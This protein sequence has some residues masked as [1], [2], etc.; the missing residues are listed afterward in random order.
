MRALARTVQKES[1]Y[2]RAPY[3]FVADDRF[4]KNRCTHSGP[5][6]RVTLRGRVRAH[7][8]S[9]ASGNQS[10]PSSCSPRAAIDTLGTATGVT[11]SWVGPAHSAAGD[12]TRYSRHTSGRSGWIEQLSSSRKGQATPIAKYAV[13]S[14]RSLRPWRSFSPAASIAASAAANLARSVS[15]RSAGIASTTC[16]SRSPSERDTG[17]SWRQHAPQPLR[18]EIGLPISAASTTAFT[19]P[20][21]AGTTSA[22]G[23]AA[24]GT[25]IGWAILRSPIVRRKVAVEWADS[26]IFRQVPVLDEGLARTLQAAHAKRQRH[27]PHLP[28]IL[29]QKR[30]RDRAVEPARAAQ[31]P[32]ADVRQLGHGAVQ[33]RLHRPG[34]ARLRARHDGAEV[35]ARRG[36]AQRPREC[37]L[38]RTPPHL[39]RDAGQLLV[40]RLLQGA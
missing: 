13:E 24:L 9:V 25:V 28:R 2:F 11:P 4:R 1:R 18:Q 26:A 6:R 29:R 10:S 12:V 3:R 39:L 30:P 17:T 8:I 14:S 31:R 23:T 7:A 21:R 20:C 19:S 35:R 36:Q 40:R 22:A 27:S 5:V 16:S 33:E 37:R 32:D 15:R 38:H 34:E